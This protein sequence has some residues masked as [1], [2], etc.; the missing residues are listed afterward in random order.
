MWLLFFKYNLCQTYLTRYY[1]SSTIF[2]QKLRN[3]AILYFNSPYQKDKKLA[4]SIKSHLQGL[5]KKTLRNFFAIS[6]YFLLQGSSFLLE[7]DP[8]IWGQHLIFKYFL[9]LG[10]K[11]IYI[12]IL[13]NIGVSGYPFIFDFFAQIYNLPLTRLSILI[14]LETFD[15]WLV[16]SDNLTYKTTLN[17][18]IGSYL[19][20]II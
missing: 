7:S 20:H 1:P 11:K 15:N 10:Q 19:E 3:V 16:V 4:S 18:S 17:I 8:D 2:Y 6:S 5:L 9:L 12:Q 14:G 13:I